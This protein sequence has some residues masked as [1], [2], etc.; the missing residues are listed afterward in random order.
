MGVAGA[1]LATVMGYVVG[2][3]IP[4]IYFAKKKRPWSSARENK[5]LRKTASSGSINGSSELMSNISASLISILYNIQLMEVIGE[6]GVAAY[7]VMM[8][9]DFAFLAAFLGFSSG[10][11]PVVSYQYGE[12]IMLS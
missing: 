10:S 3:G 6:N 5:I 9:V 7:S 2:G 12:E 11:A 1:A 4:L 8:Y